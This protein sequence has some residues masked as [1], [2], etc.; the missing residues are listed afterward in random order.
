MMGFLRI[1]H[2]GASGTRPEHTRSAFERAIEL[3]VDMIELDVQLTRDRELVVLHD[4]S[5][6]RTVA[7]SGLVREGALSELRTMD[8]GAWFG[9]AYVGQAVLSLDEVLDITAGKTMLNVEIKSPEPDWQPTAE[10]LLEILERRAQVPHTVISSFD[11]GALRCMRAATPQARLAM[12]WHEPDLDAMWRFAQEIRAENVHP[13]WPLVDAELIA[14][15]KQRGLRVLT[16]TVNDVAV[17]R[18]LVACGVDGIISDFPE[19]FEEITNG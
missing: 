3:Q 13:Y 19:R 4:L 2:R 7:G 6:G 16:W 15:A 5:F 12:L 18:Q 8:A 17:M 10:I 9:P 1:A 14:T 11:I